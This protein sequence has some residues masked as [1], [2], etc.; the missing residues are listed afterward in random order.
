MS[1]VVAVMLPEVPVMVNVL[2][3]PTAEEL[4]VKVSVLVPVVE[5]GE[6]E[7]VTPLGS[8]AI[9]RFT[10]PAKPY[11]GVTVIVAL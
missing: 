4:A 5:A 8:P 3:P 11:C 10:L 9:A 2:V 6:N 7:A 1:V